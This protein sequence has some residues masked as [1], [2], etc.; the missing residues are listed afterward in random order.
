MGPNSARPP[1]RRTKSAHGRAR[2][3]ELGLAPPG[4]GGAASILEKPPLT[5]PVSISEALAEDGG[6]RV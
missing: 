1:E 3:I 5:L 4:R 2:L 6:D